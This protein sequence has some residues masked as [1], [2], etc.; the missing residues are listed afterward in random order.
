MAL[1]ADRILLT[2][3]TTT[4]P[5][6]RT[7]IFSNY[8]RALAYNHLGLAA[9]ASYGHRSAVLPNDYVP[10]ALTTSAQDQ[11]TVLHLTARPGQA[12]SWPWLVGGKTAIR[13]AA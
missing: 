3:A 9:M 12:K 5:G 6:S 7:W 11:A 10:T 1:S 13:R 4:E 2:R 8:F